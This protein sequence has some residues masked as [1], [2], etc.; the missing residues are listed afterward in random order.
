MKF[1][2]YSLLSVLVVFLLLFI[3]MKIT[4]TNSSAIG[5]SLLSGIKHLKGD[6]VEIDQLADLDGPVM[7]HNDWTI[8]LSK[9]VN[10]DGQVN[11]PGFIADTVALTNYLEQL[12]AHP[13]GK[14]WSKEEKIAFWIN[15][16]NAF[17]VK[18]IVD[19]YPVKS[20]KDIGG[21]LTMINSPWD[22]KFFKIGNIDF[23]LNSI[24]HDILRKHFDEARI[25]F[26]INCASIS[27]PKLRSEAYTAKDLENQL[28]DQTR[29][30][31]NN[32]AKNNIGPSET[33][34]SPIFSWFEVDFTKHESIPSFLARYHSD[35]N[36]D[37]PI[38]YTDYNWN[39]N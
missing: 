30:F 6:N 36:K 29:F 32:P 27:C 22:I 25:H 28:E 18:L 7:N 9:H 14:S 34:I 37:L 16:Y 17:T 19:H 24:E 20:I 1:L 10:L 39:L 31:I 12:S 8:L 3:Y 21:N 11:Y 38:Q 4:K 2:K 5:L 23:D 13:P 35:F 33:I 15:A 26:T